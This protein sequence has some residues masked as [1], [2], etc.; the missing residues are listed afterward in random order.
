MAPAGTDRL[1]LPVAATAQRVAAA[2]VAARKRT[3]RA[4]SDRLSPPIVAVGAA[5]VDAIVSPEWAGWLGKIAVARRGSV[6][7]QR[8]GAQHQLRSRYLQGWS[9]SVEH[10][11]PAG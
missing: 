4:G 5:E 3:A 7:V 9:A 10:C 1:C 11:S 2:E 6:L 8:A